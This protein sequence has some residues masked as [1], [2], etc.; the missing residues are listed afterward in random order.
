MKEI[1]QAAETVLNKHTN[2]HHDV[3]DTRTS[4]L[5]MNPS[6]NSKSYSTTTD[7]NPYKN[8]S[9]MESRWY[10]MILLLRLAIPTFIVQLGSVTPGFIVASYI[11]RTYTSEV[12]L[13]GYTLATV[14]ANLCILSLLQG[15]YSAADTLSPQAY[16]AGSH[17]QVGYIAARGFIASMIILVPIVLL[18][19]IYMKPLL[20]WFGQESVSVTLAY[21]WF[22][23]YSMA[24][25]FYSLYQ[26]TIKFLSAQNQ[27]QPLLICCAVS[28][29]IVLPSLLFIFGSIYGF[30]GTAMA[31][32]LY[33]MF[34]SISLI[35]YL[36]YFQS[37]EPSTWPG[38]YECFKNAI[39]WKPFITYVVRYIGTPFLRATL[40]RN[41]IA[42]WS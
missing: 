41:T 6:R 20:L 11:G 27:M 14:T 12:Y 35:M 4:T 28:T 2:E 32:V 26:I 15:M 13:D 7:M 31:L 40:R 42:I 36:A 22:R 3:Y 30:I 19:F 1:A 29:G 8:V 23:I 38:L 24:L 39:Q 34:N 21:E 16:G 10:E 18:L 25:P 37:H 33:H 5:E 17:K 9:S